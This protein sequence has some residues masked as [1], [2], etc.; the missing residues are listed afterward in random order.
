MFLIGGPQDVSSEPFYF[1]FTHS[2]N[3]LGYLVFLSTAHTR[4]CV[5]GQVEVGT[6]LTARSDHTYLVTRKEMEEPL[7]R[8]K[9]DFQFLV[10]HV[11]SLGVFISSK[12][13]EKS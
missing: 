6:L 10:W 5:E 8:Y 11:S 3:K 7:N 2:S 1:Y 13:E 12:Q 9:Q 4:K